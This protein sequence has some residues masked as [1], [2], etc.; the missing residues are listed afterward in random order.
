MLNID[1]I[2]IHF[3]SRI[4][5]EKQGKKFYKSLKY[6]IVYSIGYVFSKQ[7]INCNFIRRDLVHLI[8]WNLIWQQN[9]IPNDVSKGNHNP[10]MRNPKNVLM[11]VV[12]DLT[13]GVLSSYN[14]VTLCYKEIYV[15]LRTYKVVKLLSMPILF[16]YYNLIRQVAMFH[17]RNR[18]PLHQTLIDY[19]IGVCSLKEPM[20]N[21]LCVV[22]VAHPF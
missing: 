7:I 20:R 13:T 9:A 14:K 3:W 16:F 10:T 6:L 21:N 15:W 8:W 1:S 11:I 5:Q 4:L 12:D 18:L 17:F 2:C 22:Q 19:C